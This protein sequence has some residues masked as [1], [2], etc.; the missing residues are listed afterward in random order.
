MQLGSVPEAQPDGQFVTQIVPG[1]VERGQ[2]SLLPPIIAPQGNPDI[3][4]TPILAYLYLV[5]IH[6]EQAGVVQFK[7][8]DLSQF[9][10]DRLGY[11]QCAPL[12]HKKLGSGTGGR[13]PA[14]G[15][16]P[17]PGS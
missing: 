3:R 2:G 9:L 17:A 7:T 5:N 4:V 10:A 1:M 11:A 8:N 16:S 14:R 6:V 12:V 13:E 15:F